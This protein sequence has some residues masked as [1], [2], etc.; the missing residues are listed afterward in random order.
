MA[1][2]SALPGDACFTAGELEAVTG[3]A[4]DSIR[5]ACRALVERGML[6]RRERGCWAATPEGQAAAV[7]G[8]AIISGPRG[9][10]TQE[11][12]R[13]RRAPSGRDKIWRAIRA[14]RKFA[15]NDLVALVGP[16]QVENVKDYVFAL[17][18]AGY[19]TRLRSKGRQS[20][21]LLIDDTG[22]LAPVQRDAR[23]EFFDR[24]TGATRPMN[25]EQ[26]A[27]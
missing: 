19:L 5:H 9:R 16:E 10:L 20:R 25:P 14:E 12:P 7:A 17:A 24:N 11:K 27:P 23:K 18:R 2:L 3:L 15:I 1:V 8:V 4:A 6:Q 22:P 13:T 21:F 26:V